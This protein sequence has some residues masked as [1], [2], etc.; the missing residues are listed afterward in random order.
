MADV[1]T[2]TVFAPGRTASTKA[3]VIPN[4]TGNQLLT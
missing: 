3:Q 1:K 4:E 2:V